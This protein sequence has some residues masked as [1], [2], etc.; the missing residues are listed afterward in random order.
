MFSYTPTKLVMSEP[1]DI[2]NLV[3]PPQF[4]SDKWIWKGHTLAYPAEPEDVLMELSLY[5]DHLLRIPDCDR[6]DAFRSN[7]EVPPIKAS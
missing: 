7:L 6:K 3:N 5:Y 4:N 1:N 2:L